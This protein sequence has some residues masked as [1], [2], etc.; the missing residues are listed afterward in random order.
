[1][2]AQVDP[3][4]PSVIVAALVVIFVAIAIHEYCHAKFADMAGDPTPRYF[5]RVTLNPFAHFDVFGSIMI[6]VTTLIGFGIGWGKPVP[7]DPNKMR[8]PKWDHFVAVAA[9]PLSNLGQAVIYALI[10]RL[11]TM[12]VGSAAVSGEF[13][14]L[15]LGLGVIINLSLFFFNLLP[16]GPLDGMWLLGT[17]MSDATR[18]KWTRWNLSVGSF[19][20]LGLILLSQVSNLSLFSLVLGPPVNALFRLLTGVGL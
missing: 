4:S 12:S 16:I 10:W 1:M 2:I 11:M 3:Q 7:M 19:V 8:N 17:F 13:V 14:G 15:V 5:G 20:F 9:G 18:D 6:V